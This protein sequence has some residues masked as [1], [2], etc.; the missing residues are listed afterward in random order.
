MKLKN[1]YSLW[2]GGFGVGVGVAVGK[3]V[4]VGI[5]VGV[6]IRRL[7]LALGHSS[8][9]TTSA[10]LHFRDSDLKEAYENVPF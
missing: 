9:R 5:G 7:Q 4:V 1:C 10:Y 2:S 6:D 8:I 3:G